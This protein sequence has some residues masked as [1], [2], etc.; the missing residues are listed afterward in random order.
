[1][2]VII[3]IPGYGASSSGAEVLT[4]DDSQREGAPSPESVIERDPPI[5]QREDRSRKR[6]RSND[7]SDDDDGARTPPYE[8]TEPRSSRESELPDDD[9]VYAASESESEHSKEPSASLDTDDRD[10]NKLYEYHRDLE[11]REEEA[12]SHEEAP[13]LANGEILPNVRNTYTASQ[14]GFMWDVESPPVGSSVAQ[15][16]ESM[17]FRLG[18]EVL[19]SDRGYHPAHPE[20]IEDVIPGWSGPFVITDFLPQYGAYMGLKPTEVL[21]TLRALEM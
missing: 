17:T 16:F 15:V 19:L 1:M 14:F 18:D 11:G 8:P 3:N 5:S 21:A 7:D 13:R 9:Q 12:Q 6:K 4:S 20:N 10:P 2:S